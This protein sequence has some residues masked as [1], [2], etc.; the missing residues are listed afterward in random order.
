[1][2]AYSRNETATEQ[3]RLKDASANELT[4]DAPSGPA[5]PIKPSFELY[6]ELLVKLHRPAEAAAQ[7]QHA[8]QRMPNRRASLVGLERATGQ[9]PATAQ[10]GRLSDEDIVR[11]NRAVQLFL[12]VAGPASSARE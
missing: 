11:L 5:E 2:S 10:V 9:R 6:G 7:F 4:L 8:L 3:R 1:C 12:G